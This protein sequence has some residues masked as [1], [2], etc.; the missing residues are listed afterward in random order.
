MKDLRPSKSTLTSSST[1]LRSGPI[2]RS[3]P[4]ILPQGPRLIRNPTMFCLSS[5]IRVH[6]KS[7]TPAEKLPL[8]QQDMALRLVAGQLHFQILGSWVPAAS[9]LQG[10][11]IGSRC[12][13][14]TRV[15]E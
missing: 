8:F 5:M 13:H 15:R 1:G 11:G 7:P 3:E 10:G 12:A 4:R 14:E 9:C 6:P 2:P